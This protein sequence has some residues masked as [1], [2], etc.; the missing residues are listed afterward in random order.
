MAKIIPLISCFFLL[1]ATNSANGD[2]PCQLEFQDTVSDQQKYAVMEALSQ[3]ECLLG[4]CGG[5]NITVT[6]GVI[7][8]SQI[9]NRE[10]GDAL[11]GV[12]NKKTK[13]RLILQ[14]L[15]KIMLEQ[16][17]LTD[18]MGIYQQAEKIANNN[19]DIDMVLQ[20]IRLLHIDTLGSVITDNPIV[21]LPKINN[22][23]Q[24]TQALVRY[25]HFNN[26]YTAA[27]IHSAISRRPAEEK[28]HIIL[29]PYR[30]YLWKKYLD[31]YLYKPGAFVQLVLNASIE[32]LDGF[33]TGSYS[34][35]NSQSVAETL[36]T[37]LTK[38]LNHFIN[39]ANHQ[40]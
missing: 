11:L 24:W 32:V 9:I 28:P 16:K 8:S 17:L 5:T 18:S 25:R 3:I 6:L 35:G 13:R 20:S 31:S 23:N 37:E 14:G 22:S 27:D 1:N 4:A 10:N 15:A 30:K 39:I 36:N 12:P 21:E 34:A 26:D 19:K 40:P 7:S 33:I 29:A 2:S 38:N